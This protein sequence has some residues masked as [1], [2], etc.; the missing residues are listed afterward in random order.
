M[1]QIASLFG[2]FGWAVGT[3]GSRQKEEDNFGRI[4]VTNV[5][6]IQ[7]SDLSKGRELQE[8]M[9]NGEMWSN[10]IAKLSPDGKLLAVSIQDKFPSSPLYIWDLESL[11]LLATLPRHDSGDMERDRDICRFSPDGRLVAYSTFYTAG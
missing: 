3:D 7:L 2:F 4:K 10:S 6:P 5:A 1:I 11:K 8:L 9:S